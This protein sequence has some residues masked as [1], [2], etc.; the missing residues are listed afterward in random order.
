MW[1]LIVLISDHCLSI[2]FA[3]Y[4]KQTCFYKSKVSSLRHEKLISCQE[5]ITV[6]INL[7]SNRMDYALSLWYLLGFLIYMYSAQKNT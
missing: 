1:I 3:L 6:N 4:T 5:M 7:L 2:Y